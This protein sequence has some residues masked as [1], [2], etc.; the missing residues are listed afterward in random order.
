VHEESRNE[1]TAHHGYRFQFAVWIPTTQKAN[2]RQLEAGGLSLNEEERWESKRQN[3]LDIKL[4]LAHD[5]LANHPQSN[6]HHHLRY[7]YLE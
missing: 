7:F 4:G 6:A 2:A 3:V 1:A 5:R